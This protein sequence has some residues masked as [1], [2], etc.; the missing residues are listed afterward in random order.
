MYLSEAPMPL[1]RSYWC[2][3]WMSDKSELVNEIFTT[4]CIH[5]D[6][7]YVFHIKSSNKGN[8]NFVKYCQEIL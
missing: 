7:L 3:E 8:D 1:M 2:I 4:N 5:Q 6:D